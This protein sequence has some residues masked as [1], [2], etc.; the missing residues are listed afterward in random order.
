M[1]PEGTRNTSNKLLPF[2]KGAFHLAIASQCP[3]QPVAVARY[4]F[5]SKHR[6]DAGNQPIPFAIFPVLHFDCRGNQHN[7]LAVDTNGR[8]DKGRSSIAHGQDLL[9]HVRIPPAES[10][11]KG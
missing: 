2:K 1:F 8:I 5:L 3:I 4:T 7:N 6:F 11:Q 10:F 9:R